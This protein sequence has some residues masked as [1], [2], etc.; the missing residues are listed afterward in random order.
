MSALIGFVAESAPHASVLVAG[1]SLGSVPAS[2]AIERLTS[3]YSG[4]DRTVLLT[5]GSPLELMSQVFPEIPSPDSL[6][7]TYRSAGLLL[8]WINLWR[9]KD[10]VGRALHPVR[11]E[12]FAEASLGIGGHANYWSDERVWAAI[13]EIMRAL[14]EGNLSGIG[15]AW[16]TLPLSS[17]EKYQAAEMWRGLGVVR[18]LNLFLIPGSGFYLV[19]YLLPWAK[20]FPLPLHVLICL[21][22]GIGFV[23][24]ALGAYHSVNL[25]SSPS[26]R[27]AFHDLR[28]KFLRTRMLMLFGST[29][30]A[31]FAVLRVW[32]R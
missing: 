16:K 27:E 28:F 15:R 17:G 20:Q 26:P 14:P 5:M 23:S 1:H 29:D 11:G 22:W 19:R 12:S 24:L 4:N 10:M 32:L 25:S 7:M 3:T 18:Q 13:V 8:E 6:L 31:I 30:L 2:Q 9:S 21:V